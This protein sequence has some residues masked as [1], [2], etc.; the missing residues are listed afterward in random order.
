MAKDLQK[1]PDFYPF[2]VKDHGWVLKKNASIESIG[3][4]FRDIVYQLVSK[5]FTPGSVAEA[6]YNDAVS[7]MNANTEKARKAANA[8]WNNGQNG[9]KPTPS[10]QT[11]GKPISI[12]AND[13]VTANPRGYTGASRGASTAKNSTKSTQKSR[14]PD[15]FQEVIDWC[16]EHGQ[17]IDDARQI[18]DMT[19]ERDGHDADGNKIENW[20]GYL[21]QC[22]KTK[23]ENRK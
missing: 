16:V 6:M 14:V 7:M 22:L 23:K 12:S 8:R 19:L 2:R 21:V 4:A 15:D 1:E 5:D 17:D 10:A 18:W 9:A 3:E 20:W 11:S 13:Q